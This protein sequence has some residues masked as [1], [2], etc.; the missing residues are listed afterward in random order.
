MGAIS[1]LPSDAPY[2]YNSSRP[3]ILGHRGSMG[4]FPEHTRP[5]YSSAYA[6]GVDFV[7]LDL[8]ITKDWHFITS[9]DPCLKETTDIEDHPEFAD[10]RGNFSFDFPYGD[11]Y[12]DDFL[13]HDFTLAELKTLKR[14]QRFDFR[15][16]DMNDLFPMMTLEE[17]IDL[18]YSMQKKNPTEGRSSPIGLYIETKMYEFYLKNYNIDSA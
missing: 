16:Q 12:F 4:I 7:E 1:G 14:R 18:M 5:S 8:Q 2:L 10:R 11:N 6:E 3:L 17:T 9:H 15:N 13:I